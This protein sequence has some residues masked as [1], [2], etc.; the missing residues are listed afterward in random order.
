MKI[1]FPH[2]NGIR[3]IAA[4]LVIVHHIEQIKHIL[5]LN[6]YWKSVPA[7]ELI[8][9]LGV[10]LFFVLSGFLI[11]YLLLE[12]E[13][14]YSKINIAKFYIRRILRIW[15]LYFIIVLLAFV[16]WP[17]FDQLALSQDSASSLISDLLPK[18]I[19]FAL[20]LPNMA[21]AFY[22]PVPYAAHTWSIGTEEQFYLIWPILIRLFKKYKMWLMFSIILM[23][24]SINL[25]LH[26]NMI[27]SIPYG[28]QIQ[29]FWGL[30]NIDCMAIGGVFAI[31]LHKKSP[32]LKILVSS[33]VS[34]LSVIAAALLI[35]FG[36]KFGL[37]HNEIYAVL[38]GLII[39]NFTAPNR[40]IIRLDYPLFN[41][42]G[43]ISYGLYMYHPICI[44]LAIQFCKSI[45]FMSN[46]ILIPLTFSL[47]I[48]VA[49]ASYYT[50]EKYFLHWKKKFAVVQSGSN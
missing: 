49:S 29:S 17:M 48:L 37:L 27:W 14:K 2:L 16:V 38:F 22:P 19:L 40:T 28:K 8:G 15:P 26:S 7:I 30:F 6:S 39:L 34:Y 35:A 42:L 23:Y 43:N 5:N 45:G 1:F 13:K 31:L 36:C 11:T 33:S 21:L 32:L 25:I 50:I 10:V 4:F 3:F 47:T 20:I 41:F 12:E 18:V 46:W 24:I 9:K 44:M